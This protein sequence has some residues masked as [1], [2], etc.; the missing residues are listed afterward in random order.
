M[1]ESERDRL[2]QREARNGPRRPA[3]SAIAIASEPASR[4]AAI[5]G[6]VP[7][8][9]SIGPASS[10]PAI[11]GG[12]Q[13]SVTTAIGH[14]AISLRAPISDAVA[15]PAC[16]ATSKRLRAGASSSP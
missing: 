3:L 10:L 13:A 14:L 1:E 15:V 16:N 2:A 4:P 6:G 11:A 8:R 12:M 5:V 7:S 9:R